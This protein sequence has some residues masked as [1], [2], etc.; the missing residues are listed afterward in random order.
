LFKPSKKLIGGV[1]MLDF[2]YS[3]EVVKNKIE[4]YGITYYE[5]GEAEEKIGVFSFDKVIYKHPFGEFLAVKTPKRTKVWGDYRFR[6][7]IVKLVYV[8]IYVDGGVW[9]WLLTED[10][11]KKEIKRLEVQEEEKQQEVL[12]RFRK[13][14]ME[15]DEEFFGGKRVAS[16]IWQELLHFEVVERMN[17]PNALIISCEPVRRYF[18]PSQLIIDI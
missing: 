17:A 16:Y 10:W 6:R 13:R 9:C 8:S 15:Y 11:G 2:G 14:R 12:E 5:W 18:T 7:D 4:V 3:F 1:A